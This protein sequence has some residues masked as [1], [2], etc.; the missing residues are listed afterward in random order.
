MQ[1]TT[2]AGTQAQRIALMAL[3]TALVAVLSYFG[4]FIKIGGFASISLTLIPVVLG[5]AILGPLTGAWL[6]AGRYR[7]R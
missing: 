4:G 3:L 1:T 5:A 2:K 7:H 6:G